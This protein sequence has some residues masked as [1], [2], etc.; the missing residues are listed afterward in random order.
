MSKQKVLSFIT[1]LIVVLSNA[2]FA[3]DHAGG[4]P[5]AGDVINMQVN[6]CNLNDGFTIEDYNKMN[7]EYF[8][9]SKTN[10]VEVTFVRQ[11]PV[12]THNSPNNPDQYEFYGSTFH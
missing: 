5:K 9:W 1:S 10:D 3:D 12:F 2:A 8:K 7:R 4:Q 6:L 11:A